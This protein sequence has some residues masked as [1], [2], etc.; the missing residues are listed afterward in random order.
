MENAVTDSSR[1][2]IEILDLSLD[3]I[4]FLFAAGNNP[5]GPSDVARALDINRSRAF[6]ILKTLEQRGYVDAE[7]DGEGY[8]L[9]LRFLEIGE[10]I[11]G[12]M[13]IRRVAEPVLIELARTTGD[14]VNLFVRS[15][16]HAVLLDSHR[17]HHRLQIE[18]PIGMTLPFHVGA[19]PKALLAF[20]PDVEREQL[21]RTIELAR[22]T[23]TTI[24]AR[25]DLDR[26]L[27]EIRARGYVI[28]EGDYE[29]G[30]YSTGAP[31]HDQK[32]QV[33][34]AISVVT[35]GARYTTA[36]RDDLVAAVTE[37]AGR[38]SAQLGWQAPRPS[39]G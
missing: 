28:D 29:V 14:T 31:V 23:P 39:D 32:G 30:V 17:G 33:I 5:V 21:V 19:S 10:K 37:A 16:L 13:D 4:E 25:D 24:T 15:G 27:A 38:I 11:R 6:R 20:L 26:T 1:Y 2:R 22:F 12:R 3:V 35:P 36:R 8:R 18:D 7:P 9:G 34:A